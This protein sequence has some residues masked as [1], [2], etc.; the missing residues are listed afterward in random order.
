[1]LLNQLIKF[2]N[3]KKMDENTKL[4]LSYDLL[5]GSKRLN[6]LSRPCIKR[7]LKSHLKSTLRKISPEDWAT[8]MLLPVEQFVGASK[9]TVW[10]DSLR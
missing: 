5:Q 8:A 1:M 7:Y 4:K 6:S 2:A 10:R 9:A 3:D